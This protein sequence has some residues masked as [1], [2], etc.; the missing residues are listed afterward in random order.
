ML[1]Q[2]LERLAIF[3]CAGLLAKHVGCTNGREGWVILMPRWPDFTPRINA[4]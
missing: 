3:V 1:P 4:C 2:P